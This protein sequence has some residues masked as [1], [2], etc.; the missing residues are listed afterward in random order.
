GT[1]PAASAASVS[2]TARG[3][4]RWC[5]TVPALWSDEAKGKVRR[6][7]HRA[8]LITKLDSDELTVVLEPE[9]AAL[10]V[11]V[12]EDR[13]LLFPA[14]LLSPLAAAASRYA[15]TAAA[16]TSAAAATAAAAASAETAKSSSGTAPLR[17][18]EVFMVVD[19]GGGT[20]DITIHEIVERSGTAVL[21][22]AQAVPGLGEMVGSTN[23][24]AAF[25]T[26]FR[27]KV[28]EE[29]YDT[30]RETHPGEWMRL[31]EGTWEQ[32]KCDFDSAD[33]PAGVD[34]APAGVR[35]SDGGDEEEEDDWAGGGSGAGGHRSTW[36][37]YIP[38]TLHAAMDGGVKA[39]LLMEHGLDDSVVL[40]R[41]TLAEFFKGAVQGVIKAA[42]RQLDALAAA[43][44]APATRCSKVMLVGGFG[45]SRY[46]QSQ[47]VA[48][49][50]GR[51]APGGGMLVPEHPASAVMRGA[52]L[53]GLKP[54]LVRARSSRMTYGVRT[55]V[56]Y[57]D[58]MPAKFWHPAE[59]CYYSAAG[60]STFVAR[61]QLVAADE[62][63]TH[64]FTPLS[65]NQQ[66]ASVEL[67]ATDQQH[68]RWIDAE[69]MPL[70]AGEVEA[71]SRAGGNGGSG[72]G[73]RRVGEVQVDLTQEK[74]LPA[75]MFVR[76]VSAVGSGT[77]ESGGDDAE[78]RLIEVS[79]EFGRTEIRV[80]A[81]DMLTGKSCKTRV[82]FAFS[83]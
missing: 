48:A 27:S 31:L 8:A 78:E 18:D 29:V 69:D 80:T 73:M 28:G 24:D 57:E 46:L 2:A 55:A 26:Y 14:A 42:Q 37:V 20:V 47:L 70:E 13:S 71:R 3:M 43:P 6:A 30:W 61:G 79:L 68:V 21:S 12:G 11:S 63:V 56:P 50:G 65:P 62:V 49:V 59:C 16:A 34:L 76:F 19:A 54:E 15:S 9:A 77:S 22:E 38:P 83:W 44:R 72:G 52:V 60:F 35:K 64:V 32:I 25:A 51:V 39:D 17:P 67:W 75:A 36:R 66:V 45:C 10:Q 1:A 58:G 53:Y 41:R 33:E 81:Q 40:D 4:I 23:V 5:L 74:P 82:K 7:A